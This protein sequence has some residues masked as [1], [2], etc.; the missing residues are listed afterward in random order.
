MN[1]WVIHGLA[2]VFF[3]CLFMGKITQEVAIK[4]M[5]FFS[6]IGFYEEEQLLGN[7]FFVDL[8][9][10]FTFES[11]DTEELGNTVNYE[12]LFQLLHEVM[13]PKRKLLESAAEELLQ[14]AREKYPFVHKI[15]VSIQKT[16]P[17]F[18]WDVLASA[19]SLTYEK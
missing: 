6:P 9:V 8:L 4:G 12:E 17:P 16:T 2:F 1:N 10:V 5:R 14:K 18:G 7:E 3:L 15:H 11:S 19:V 13:R